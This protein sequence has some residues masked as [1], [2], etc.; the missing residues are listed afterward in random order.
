MVVTLI[1]M[2]LV[3]IPRAPILG[4]RCHEQAFVSHIDHPSAFFLQLAHPH[5]K[6]EELHEEIK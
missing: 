1:S 3:R 2:L 5:Q 6:F 4:S